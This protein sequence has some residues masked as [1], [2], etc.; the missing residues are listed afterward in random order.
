MPY[1]LGPPRRTQPHG[2]AVY[3]Q[4][5]P[6]LPPAERYVS[7]NETME[8]RVACRSQ[9]VVLTVATR[10]IDTFGLLQNLT[11]Q[12]TV[13]APGTGAKP[14]LVQISEC[15]LLAALITI[16]AAIRGQCF[17]Q[18]VLLRGQAKQPPILGDILVQ[19]YPT[20]SD[21]IG[22]PRSPLESSISGKGW[23]H[24][25]IGVDPAGPGPAIVTVPDGVRWYVK[26]ARFDL[27]SADNPNVLKYFLTIKDKDGNVIHDASGPGGE[28]MPPG[29]T[30]T[31]V[32]QG[33]SNNIGIAPYTM[34]L[35]GA[36]LAG[37]TIEGSVFDVDGGAFVIG[38]LRVTVE[39]FV[40]A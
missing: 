24:T 15:F 38:A 34:T 26:N 7:P 37:G 35:S 30:I 22:Y 39:E 10:I 18:L 27:I 20:T 2:P 11:S 3:F 19:G 28:G 36:V 17:V 14:L 29:S 33:G 12:Y 4:L 6:V 13:K 23:V 31:F 32:D 21:F 25:E 40:E 1:I 16:D 5:N 8:L 9:D